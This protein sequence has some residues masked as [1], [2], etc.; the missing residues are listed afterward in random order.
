MKL[1]DDLLLVLVRRR[2]ARFTL[3]DTAAQQFSDGLL[4]AYA[5]ELVRRAKTY[6]DFDP[7]AFRRQVAETEIRMAAMAIY[8]NL[9]VGT[10]SRFH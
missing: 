1:F 5:A 8:E 4:S 6:S 3:H 7:E 10:E 9:E 2:L